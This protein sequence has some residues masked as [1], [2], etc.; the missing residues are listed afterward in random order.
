MGSSRNLSTWC[1]IVVKKGI[2]YSYNN[3]MEKEFKTF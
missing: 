1:M 2:K 3:K